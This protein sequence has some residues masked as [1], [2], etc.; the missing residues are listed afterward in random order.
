MDYFE[1]RGQQ[2]KHGV[3]LGEMIT[4]KIT[5][6]LEGIDNIKN[7]NNYLTNLFYELCHN[8]NLLYRLHKE[9]CEKHKVYPEKTAT[10]PFSPKLRNQ[11]FQ[12]MTSVLNYE[13]TKYKIIH[14]SKFKEV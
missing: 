5:G 7:K 10:V 1:Y 2:S 12:I 3:L 6:I 4:L 13:I 14:S 9:Y 11:V 8:D